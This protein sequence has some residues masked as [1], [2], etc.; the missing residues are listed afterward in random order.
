M[1]LPYNEILGG[2]E[3]TTEEWK[4]LEKLSSGSLSMLSQQQQ[5]RYNDLLDQTVSVD[6]HPEEYDG[7][8]LCAMCV[9]YS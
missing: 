2:R 9:S 7:A 5:I 8:C 3:M 6:E 1:Q 4:E